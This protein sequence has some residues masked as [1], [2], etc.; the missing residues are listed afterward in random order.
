MIILWLSI[1][2]YAY[3]FE[4]NGI[5][6]DIDATAG[7][8]VV[9]NGDTPYTGE[10][11]VP[12][13]ISIKNRDLLVV[14]IGQAFHNS[15]ITSISIGKNISEIQ[16][17]AF[18][19]C[20]SLREIYFLP[21]ETPIKINN[22]MVYNDYY[23]HVGC[24][25]KLP[26]EKIVFGRSVIVTTSGYYNISDGSPFIYSNYFGIKGKCTTLREAVFNGSCNSI[27]EAI[28]GNS[29]IQSLV[30]GES[31]REI[32][33]EAFTNCNSLEQIQINN[34]DAFASIKFNDT[35]QKGRYLYDE[36]GNVIT[37]LVLQGS[38][39]SSKAFSGVH[40]IESITLDDNVISVESN[41][42]N[43]VPS[44]KT[45]KIMGSNTTWGSGVFGN[46]LQ[47]EEIE[48]N[49]LNSI[50]HRMIE[51]C[52]AI[53]S[54]SCPNVKNIGENAFDGCNNLENINA[55]ILSSLGSHAFANTK[56]NTINLPLISKVGNY[57]FSNCNSLL[58]VDFG[59][60]ISTLGENIFDE[61]KNLSSVTIK[62]LNPPTSNNSFTNFIYVNTT[63]NV[64]ELSVEE[65]KSR[66]PWSNFFEINSI[67]LNYLEVD[68][69]LYYVD[70]STGVL[71][72]VVDKDVETLN[73]PQS[74]IYNSE[75]VIVSDWLETCFIDLTSLKNLTLPSSFYDLPAINMLS[76]LEEVSINSRCIPENYFMDLENLAKINLGS[77][78][79]SI[80]NN[81][82]KNCK[83]LRSIQI[84]A[85]CVE[86]GTDAFGGCSKLSN[87]I[88]DTSSQKIT[89]GYNSTLNLSS[90]ITPFPNP[91]DVD[92]RRTG[93]RNGYYDGL[94]FG[95]P[96]E[97]LVINRDIELPKYYE[98][99]LGNSTSGYS[100]VYNDIVYY[101][102]F[103]S[104]TNLKY[105][106][107]GDNVSS[108]CK[109]QIEA[110]V[111]AVPTTMGYTNFGKC[112]NIEVVVSNN[113][114]API[115]GG[116]SQT[117]YE[118][119]SLFLPNGGID[120]Y[121][122]DDYWKNFVHINEASFIPIESIS[123]ESDEVVIDV[124]ESKKLN[125]IINPSEA[126]IRNLKW[127]SSNASIVN[128]SEDG[129]ITTS[130]RDGEAIITATTCDGSCV[131]GSIKVIV[132]EKTGLSD[133]L[134]D[135]DI[136]ICVENG[137]LYIRGKSDTD[138]VSVYNVQ[139]QLIISTND[140]RIDLGSKG[141]Y[142]VK[143][144]SISKKIVI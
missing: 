140:N 97:H 125:P 91:S 80:G 87:V 24:F 36:E 37:S 132:Q 14:S 78:I 109:N 98:R 94:F 119:A 96:I 30:I 4:V 84:P 108:I 18:D 26:L 104:L 22:Q 42:F 35:P 118:N 102:P 112:D 77:N 99:T 105:L 61:C 95:L 59:V 88:F 79:V 110:V 82:F 20:N 28:C 69:C 45:V 67:Q 81:A 128:V 2:A 75:S 76:T 133:V 5:F 48:L 46:N 93:F 114:N 63:L 121:K 103:Y 29:T 66:S 137:K 55:P 54:L 40:G 49:Q 17:G 33:S 3:D 8:A 144:D 134:S 62:S 135:Y 115:G 1:P 139:G 51:S 58:N 136:D 65:Y 107:I 117:V 92:E 116:F 138:V 27:P 25:Y 6:Y 101:P 74:I 31:V 19:G 106:E 89:L 60:K 34:I 126:S 12:D 130:S 23:A 57:V 141:I 73:I 111:K 11:I 85:A 15:T 50:G 13:V 39:I 32:G 143:V 72:S 127:S 68:G 100:T 129:I 83:S 122:S 41:A 86:I 47:L 124:N 123:F 7:T 131:S 64:P 90:S 113:T 38:L 16:F 142:I 71:I 70:G 43:E 52:P 10:I 120:S 21:S 53:K 9:T 56:L 44:L